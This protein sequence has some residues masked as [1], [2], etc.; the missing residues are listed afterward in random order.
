MGPTGV[1]L[2]TTAPV[3]VIILPVVFV[4]HVHSPLRKIA[5]IEVVGVGLGL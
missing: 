2:P 4:I 5:H 1:N 3:M